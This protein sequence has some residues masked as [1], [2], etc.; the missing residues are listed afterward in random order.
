MIVEHLMI[1]TPT[2]SWTDGTTVTEDLIVAIVGKKAMRNRTV[3]KSK[4][5]TKLCITRMYHLCGS[6]LIL[7]LIV[8]AKK[9]KKKKK[10]IYI[11]IYMHYKHG[12]GK[13]NSPPPLHNSQCEWRR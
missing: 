4:K 9:K 2:T 12:M 6:C 8:S 5:N 7:V 10:N 13:Y 3:W 1:G 11:Y